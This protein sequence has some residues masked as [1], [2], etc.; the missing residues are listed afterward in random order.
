[1]TYEMTVVRQQGTWDVQSI[2]ASTTALT[3]GPP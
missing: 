3:Q 2:G 1:M